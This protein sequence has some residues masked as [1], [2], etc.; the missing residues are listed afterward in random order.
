MDDRFFIFGLAS[1]A[2]IPIFTLT[3]LQN[4]IILISK[5]FIN[6]QLKLLNIITMLFSFCLMFI[7]ILSIGESI[8]IINLILLILILSLSINYTYKDY[9][10]DEGY[11]ITIPYFIIYSCLVFI[12]S[13][14][15]YSLFIIESYQFSLILLCTFICYILFSMSIYFG[16]DF[17][18]SYFNYIAFIGLFISTFNVILIINCNKKMKFFIINFLIFQ[19]IHIYLYLAHLLSVKFELNFQ[20]KLKSKFFN[21]F[22]KKSIYPT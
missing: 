21:R 14:N 6:I 12:I 13:I 15:E 22:N 4:E 7:N 10:I 20:S 8:R 18:R 5:L 19:F 16:I 1:L 9:T 17:H 2:F 3:Y 11:Y